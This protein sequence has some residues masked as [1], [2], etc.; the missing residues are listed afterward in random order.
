MLLKLAKLSGHPEIFHSIQGEGKSLGVP[1]IF[2]RTSLCN[3]H[4]VWCDTDYTWNWLGTRFPHENDSR[5]GYKK[6]DK[7]DWLVEL[8]TEKVADAVEKFPC[9]NIIL[10]GGE[11]ML[12]Q[13]ALVDL[14][15]I[16]KKRAPDYRFEIETNGTLVPTADF[17][18]RIDQFNV[19]PKLSNAGMT[20]KQTER[21]AA[22]RFFSKNPKANFKFV[23][24]Q[25]VDLQE[26]M[27]L[28]ERYGI[29]PEQVFLM[30]EGRTKS[31]LAARRKW[32]AEVCKKY[33]FRYTD[34]LHIQ[35]WGSKKG[36]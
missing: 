14:M 9:K 35:I 25:K 33:N 31:A 22:L 10:T 4:C 24:A 12:Q 1:S 8:P 30:P 17:E 28:V 13:P 3:L 5:P 16:L 19:S 36:V 7:K 32:L 27:S 21:P 6:F 15:Q 23:V 34:R 11:P 20:K 26:V 2:V 18:K 29:L